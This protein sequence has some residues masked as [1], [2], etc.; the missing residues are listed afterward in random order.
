MSIKSVTN[1]SYELGSLLNTLLKK[2]QI[3]FFLHLLAEA[4][5]SVNLLSP[6]SFL[7]QSQEN[8][9]HT[10]HWFVCVVWYQFAN[11]FIH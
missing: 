10:F 2:V 1:I 6:C 3:S 9:T 5:L 7:K 4:M 11:K 8:L